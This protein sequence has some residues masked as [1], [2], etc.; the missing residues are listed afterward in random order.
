MSTIA[1][2]LL[3]LGVLVITNL[4]TFGYATWRCRQEAEGTQR[5]LAEAQQKQRAAEAQ[6]AAS[7]QRLERL[8]VWGELLELQRD[9][10]GVH[11]VINQLNF[12]NAIQA[13]DRVETRLR[14]GEYGQLFRQRSP[15]LLPL[16]EQAKG[17]LRNTDP[18]ARTYLV[19]LD[20]R[21]FGILAATAGPGE[22]PGL[23]GLEPPTTATPAPT[24]LPGLFPDVTP[25]LELPPSPTPSP[26]ATGTAKPGA[27]VKPTPTP[28]SGVI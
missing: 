18:M 22:L 23:S 4:G 11:A 21:A 3:A 7:E 17:A 20:Q 12:G 19:E 10:N 6:N 15:E 14:Q 1:K 2:A 28:K 25:T 16:L 9:V 8:R 26:T 5:L 13:I 24:P 27:T